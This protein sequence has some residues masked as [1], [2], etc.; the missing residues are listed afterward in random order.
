MRTERRLVNVPGV[1]YG[2]EPGQPVHAQREYVMGKKEASPPC[3]S[4]DWIPRSRSVTAYRHTPYTRILTT[5]VH[6]FYR[7][8]DAVESRSKQQAQSQDCCGRQ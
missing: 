6:T 8:N 7:E 1:Q 3:H 4:S 2:G 5:H